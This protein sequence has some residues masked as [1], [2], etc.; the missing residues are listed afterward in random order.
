MQ[1][2]NLPALG[3]I[4]IWPVDR[5]EM[6]E[7]WT[8]NGFEVL[9]RPSDEDLQMCKCGRAAVRFTGKSPNKY[10]SLMSY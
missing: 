7:A 10:L 4:L 1:M 8:G 2:H 5:L 6:E 9:A 3:E